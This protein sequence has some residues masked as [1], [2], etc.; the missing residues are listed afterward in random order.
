MKKII[1]I[2]KNYEFKNVFEKGKYYKGSFLEIFVIRKK[3]NFNRIGIAISKK[4]GNS[5]ERNKIK[6]LIRES[7]MQ[8]NENLVNGC[9]IIILWNKKVE[10]KDAN[11]YNIKEDLY[12][13][14]KKAEIIENEKN[15]SVSN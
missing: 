2:K 13:V 10:I 9:E 7:Y 14:F 4:I 12:E 8:L 6:R 1:T 15:P 11:F 5:V 3:Q